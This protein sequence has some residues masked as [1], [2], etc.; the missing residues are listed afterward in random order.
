MAVVKRRAP[1]GAGASRV[2]GRQAAVRSGRRSGGAG[3]RARARV[4]DGRA[5]RW[6]P[7]S[8]GWTR[9]GAHRRAAA[10]D[11][12]HL[13]AERLL[14]AARGRATGVAAAARGA[15]I[16]WRRW[17]PTTRSARS[18]PRR[19]R[20]RPASPRAASGSSP[21]RAPSRWH[22]AGYIPLRRAAWRRLQ[23][24]L[25]Q[26]IETFG[27]ERR[28]RLEPV[29][30]VMRR[31]R[32]VGLQVRPR[33]ETIGCHWLALVRPL[34]RRCGRRWA[35][36]PRRVPPARPP[37]APARDRLPLRAGAAGRPPGA[38][39]GNAG[40][41]HRDRRS[42]APAHRGQ[43]H[44]RHHRSPAPRATRS[45]SRSG[46]SAPCPAHLVDAGPELPARPARA[47]SSRRWSASGPTFGKHIF[48]AR[49]SLRRPR[50]PSV[51]RP[52]AQADDRQDL[53]QGAATGVAVVPPPLYARAATAPFDVAG[54]P[55]ATG[56]KNLLLVGPREPPRAR[57][58][59]R[60]RL[61]LGRGAPRRPRA[62]PRVPLRRRTLLGS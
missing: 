57:P 26:R 13:A 48:V 56:V 54:L 4:R 35:P 20:C 21:R 17:R 36:P 18:P 8:S 47:A 6:P 44:R 2:V 9:C 45:T 53:R 38:A 46:S 39:R 49:L 52:T 58:R 15:A 5:D 22:V 61:R 19:P 30:V 41:H 50:R 34:R 3:A 32:A 16:R 1:A 62:R 60:A 24:L 10:G 25:Y 33:D 12:D 23:E 59:G 14:G 40:A 43:R 28:R 37:G 42:G 29:G 27:G 11:G 31:G 7:A 51:A 55:H